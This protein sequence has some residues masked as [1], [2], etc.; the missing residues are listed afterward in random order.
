MRPA[1][2]LLL[3]GGVRIACALAAG[4]LAIIAV[5]ARR[6]RLR[7]LSSST[8]YVRW[9]TWALAAPLFLAAVVWPVACLAFVVAL[10]FQGVREFSALVGLDGW[11]RRLLLMAAVST[12]VLAVLDF[13]VWRALPPLLLLAATLPP[14]LSQDCER[15][16][17]KLAFTGLGFAYIPWLLTY[18]CLLR[19][20]TVGG[21]G[22]LLALGVAIAASDVFAYVVGR[23]VRSW[24]LAPRLS[25]NKTIAGVA[26]N[27]LGAAAGLALMRF[28]KPVALPDS[29]YVALAVVVVAGCVWGDLLESLLKRQFGAKDA[30]TWLPGFG[31][32][33]DRIDSLIVVAPL[34]YTV[35]VVGMTVLRGSP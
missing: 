26:G 23:A 17:T 18:V 7:S 31:G 29:L 8:L 19:D 9:R 12:P 22:V 21:A 28:A 33:L 32:L 10:A 27:A 35:Q 4:L 14:L 11:P 16:A 20:R 13:T 15:G 25:P 6:G 5:E 34:A 1:T 30:G 24:K 2:E 3:P